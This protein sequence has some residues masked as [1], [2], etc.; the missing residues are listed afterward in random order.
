[1]A[2]ILEQI[3]IINAS[4]NASDVAAPEPHKLPRLVHLQE[5]PPTV[6]RAPPTSRNRGVGDST[7]DKNTVNF[8][9]ICVDLAIPPKVTCT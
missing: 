7:R 6:D 3:I 5:P 9:K 8:D 4:K 2:R 1:M